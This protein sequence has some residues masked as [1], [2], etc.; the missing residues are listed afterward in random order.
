VDYLSAKVVDLAGLTPKVVMQIGSIHPVVLHH[1]FENELSFPF[2]MNL[3]RVHVEGANLFRPRL[4]LKM[5]MRVGQT[6]SRVLANLKIFWR[7]S[8]LRHE[9]LDVL[10]YSVSVELLPRTNADLI[11]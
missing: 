3:H 2:D 8:T 10:I 11:R 1:R 5:L 9:Q 4:H 7:S 6:P